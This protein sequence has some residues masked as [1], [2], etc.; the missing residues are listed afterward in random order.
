MPTEMIDATAPTATTWRVT[1][2]CGWEDADGATAM[3]A[4][5]A[6]AQHQTNAHPTY[7]PSFRVRQHG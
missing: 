3:A 1:C 6:V 2:A 7:I 5:A 4:M